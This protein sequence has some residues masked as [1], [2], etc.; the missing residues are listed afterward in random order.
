MRK[1]SIQQSTRFWQV[2]T[3]SV[4]VVLDQLVIR[5]HTQLMEPPSDAHEVLIFSMDQLDKLALRHRV[6]TTPSA[7]DRRPRLQRLGS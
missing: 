6:W 4:W 5:I 7:E 2:C 1:S 3:F